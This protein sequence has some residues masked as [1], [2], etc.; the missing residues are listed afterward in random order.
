MILHARSSLQGASGS[1]VMGFGQI[2]ARILRMR[3]ATL[4][5]RIR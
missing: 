2:V 5:E 4:Y 3:R 1:S